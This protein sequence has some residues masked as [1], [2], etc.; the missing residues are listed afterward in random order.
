MNIW[1]FVILIILLA[2]AY[3]GFRKG[4][5]RS[6]V[7]LLALLAGVVGAI[8]WMD[9]GTQFLADTFGLTTDLLPVL[10]FLL[11][12]IVIVISITLIGS[13]LKMLIDLTPLG[14]VDGVSG[15]LLGLTKWALV[16]SLLLWLLDTASV[17]LPAEEESTLYSQVRQLAPYVLNEASKWSPAFE[18]LLESIVNFFKELTSQK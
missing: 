5:L 14:L 1:D 4:L 7:S 13:L 11:I 8:Q 15:A 10:S 6:V 9:T 17:N 12:F 18:Q 16:L 2:G 3:R